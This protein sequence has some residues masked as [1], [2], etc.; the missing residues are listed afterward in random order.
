MAV[1][2]SYLRFSSDPQADG[3]T[4]RRQTAA[5]D[6]WLRHRPDVHLDKSL[7]PDRGV[8]GY[9]GKHR[10]GDHGLAQ[11]LALVERGHVPAGSYLIVENLDRLTREEPEESIPLVMNL[12]RVGVKVVQLL[13]T[14][15]VYER[16]MDFG[17][18]TMMLWELARGHSESKRRSSLLGEVW[19]EK[20]RKAREGGVPYGR[21]C[22]AW[23]TL[24]GGRYELKPDAAAAVRRAFELCVS[25]LG[26]TSIVARLEEE[27][28]PAIGKSGKWWRFYVHQL[29]RNP[30]ATGVYQPMTGS[31]RR[32]PDGEPI[33][34]Y[35]PAVV[36]EGLFYRAQA[37]L[38]ARK[39]RSG[40]PATACSNPFSGLL[41]DALSGE[42]LYAVHS[43]GGYK[44]LYP[45]SLVHGRR[46]SAS[47][48]G[49][50]LTPLVEA[51]LGEMSELS[52]SDLFKAPGGGR[53]AELEGRL[54][55]EGRRLAAA[56][57]KWELDPES[58][59]WQAL[60]DKHDR[61]K[62]C[63][64]RE[65]AA[66]RAAAANPLPAA[67]EDVLAAVEPARLRQAL[68]A[69]VEGVYCLFI[70]D[71][72]YDRTALVQAFFRGGSIRWWRIRHRSK[73]AA[74]PAR[75]TWTYPKLAS[76][77]LR[78]VEAARTVEA[79]NRRLP[80]PDALRGR[81]EPI[82]SSSIPLEEQE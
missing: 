10:T 62:R 3:D 74:P 23:L 28:V 9:R 4:E 24:E 44:Y 8:S 41:V 75:E 37:A 70:R 38:G 32:A 6:A 11:F 59:C 66:A 35:Y 36:T 21:Q 50:P 13:P 31:G 26:L 58:T 67:W 47:R 46:G 12:I 56:T 39:R 57:A 5:R 45:A 54:A 25:G 48:C 49:F 72:R 42:K 22:P 27:G 7:K 17:R 34:G 52:A 82:K 51:L 18:M 80:L 29:L 76:L 43:G 79:L 61:G 33:P 69:T 14:E 64:E 16:G 40:R 60:V 15:T 65:L 78:D 55:A 81:Q 77:D 20:K 1:A 30:A 68:L 19:K 71:G 2:F 53:V 73:P 63:L